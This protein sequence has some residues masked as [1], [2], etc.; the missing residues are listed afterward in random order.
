MIHNVQNL[1]FKTTVWV[2]KRIAS[3]L[4]PFPKRGSFP[5]FQDT[6]LWQV[7]LTCG[8]KPVLMESST[9][10]AEGLSVATAGVGVHSQQ[11]LLR[12]G[13]GKSA[14]IRHQHLCATP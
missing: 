5:L 12:V 2:V 4:S 6:P 8:G 11:C 9:P 14:L 13:S 7:G 1:E 3:L 10:F